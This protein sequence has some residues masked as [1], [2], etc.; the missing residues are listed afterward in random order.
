MD[1]CQYQDEDPSGNDEFLSIFVELEHLLSSKILPFQAKLY[2]VQFYKYKH[3]ILYLSFSS[4]SITK[5]ELL[6]Q[7]KLLSTYKVL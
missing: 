6:L 3:E 5:T 1:K 7:S 4:L 2:A